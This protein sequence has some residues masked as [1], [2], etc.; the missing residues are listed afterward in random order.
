MVQDFKNIYAQLFLKIGW[1]VSIQNT[2]SCVR[3][4]TWPQ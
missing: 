2:F 3:D 1:Q 4:E